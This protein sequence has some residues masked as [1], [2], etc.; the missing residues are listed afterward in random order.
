MRHAVSKFHNEISDLWW[1][2]LD[3]RTDRR[4][5]EICKE[6]EKTLNQ[7]VEDIANALHCRPGLP[8]MPGDMTDLSKDW[9]NDGL[10]SFLRRLSDTI[11]EENFF[12]DQCIKRLGDVVHGIRTRT[13]NYWQHELALLKKPL[14]ERTVFGIVRDPCA[15][16]QTDKFSFDNID[17]IYGLTAKLHKHTTQWRGKAAAC[18][19]VRVDAHGV[20]ATDDAT[21]DATD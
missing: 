3:L 5:T 2:T 1:L 21:D 17:F 6:I 11:R 10:L 15:A 19:I 14:N 7:L 16:E 18:G 12:V 4:A 20:I 8:E 9:Y 13:A